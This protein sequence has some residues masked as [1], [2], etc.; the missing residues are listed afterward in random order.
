[1]E[2][3]QY[4]FV[5]GMRSTRT[6]LTRW[7]GNP[8]PVLGSWF[9]AA[10]AIGVV[11]LVS[12]LAIAT[13]VKPDLGFGYVPGR[14]QGPELA[15]M[16]G[17]VGKN[18]LVLALHAVACVAGFI[19][20]SSLALSAEK[21][22]GVSRWIHERARPVAFAW[23][24]FVTCFSLLAQAAALGVY[25]STL[26]DSAGISP[27]LLV[28]TVLPHALLELTAVFLPLAA[29]TIASRRDEWDQ[30]L[31]AT[32]VT[33]TIAVPMLI[34]SAAWEVHVWPYLLRAA[35]PTI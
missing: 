23:V 21:R 28:A 7:Q 9:A 32:V 22:K 1:M 3:N 16:A 17:L 24:I 10:A 14:P 19:A 25:G 20:G 34:L 31:A 2:A 18:S 6:A 8:L 13:T 27:A 26:A 30:L 11:L 4:A 12:V 33:V 5:H 15:H 29:W 35:S